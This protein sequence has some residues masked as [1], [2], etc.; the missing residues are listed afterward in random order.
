MLAIGRIFGPDEEFPILFERKPLLSPRRHRRIQSVSPYH[1]PL[2]SSL[3]TQFPSPQI[4]KDRFELSL[5]FPANLD[6]SKDLEVKLDPE[7]GELSVK[8]HREWS[9]ESG[10]RFQS[11]HYEH[12]CTVPDNL[13]QDRLKCRMNENG[14]LS[15]EAPLKPKEEEKKKPEVEKKLDIEI[16]VQI[17]RRVSN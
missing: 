17:V 3:A 16:P 2:T 10:D 15:I 14:N 7:N 13:I 9:S 12:R 8:G 5:P 4:T 11:Y 1:R 6:P